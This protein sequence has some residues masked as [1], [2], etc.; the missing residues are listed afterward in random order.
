M[1]EKTGQNCF[2]F[3]FFFE[4]YNSTSFPLNH[5]GIRGPRASAQPELTGSF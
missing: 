1:Y 2:F 5:G 3:F 4:E